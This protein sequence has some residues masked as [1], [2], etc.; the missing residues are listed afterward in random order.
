MEKVKKGVFDIK[1]RKFRK[2]SAHAQNFLASLIVKDP[3][4]RI[5]AE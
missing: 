4:K 3:K 2:L 5:T 1:D